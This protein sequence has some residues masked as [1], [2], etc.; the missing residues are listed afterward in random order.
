MPRTRWLGPAL[1]WTGC[2]PPLPPPSLSLNFDGESTLRWFA[3]VAAAVPGR[4][5]SRWPYAP[6]RRGARM[7]PGA[8]LD[9][10]AATPLPPRP[11]R[12]PPPSPDLDRASDLRGPSCPAAM[13]TLAAPPPCCSPASPSRRAHSLTVA[14]RRADR[15]LRWP[16]APTVC[17]LDRASDL[18]GQLPCCHA[19]LLAAPPPC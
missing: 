17:D 19:D 14:A 11:P 5:S 7:A 6:T 9:W 12:S 3:P 16:S 15:L 10:L 18:R 8:L 4:R 13:R 2:D 1:R